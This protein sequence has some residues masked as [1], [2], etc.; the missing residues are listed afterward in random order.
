MLLGLHMGRTETLSKMV[1]RSW[2]LA[3]KAAG[4]LGLSEHVPKTEQECKDGNTTIRCSKTAVRWLPGRAEP[5]VRLLFVSRIMEYV[6][7]KMH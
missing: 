6:H 5:P 4:A 3:G 2:A 7:P 1:H